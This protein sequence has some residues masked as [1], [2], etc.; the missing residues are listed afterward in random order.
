[1]AIDRRDV[2]HVAGLSRLELCEEEI[3]TFTS[4]LARIVDYV[5]KLGEL[6]V[7][8]DEPMAH[9]AEGAL[10]REDSPRASLPRKAA[11]EGAPASGD[12][13]FRVPPVIEDE[14]TSG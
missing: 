13:F 5:D 12:G 14:G 10:L 2:E 11:L 4:Q 8:K 7:S 9:A 3:E 1:M 6:D